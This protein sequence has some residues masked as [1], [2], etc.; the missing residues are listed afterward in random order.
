MRLR[1][2]SA[3]QFLGSL[4]Q[5]CSNAQHRASQAPNTQGN[6]WDKF[7]I[8]FRGW[9]PRLDK[10][11]A[12][13]HVQALLDTHDIPASIG[14]IRGKYV[15]FALV[16]F[17]SLADKLAFMSDAKQS[18]NGLDLQVNGSTVTLKI[19]NM[20]PPHIKVQSDIV[21]H[22]VWHLRNEVMSEHSDNLEH[23]P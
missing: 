5:L 16:S 19:L 8:K 17:E 13:L 9:P 18:G 23:E 21:K 10:A 3:S 12:I 7:E 14:D 11:S 20:V 22:V 15:D 4:L 1:T 2:I 6:P